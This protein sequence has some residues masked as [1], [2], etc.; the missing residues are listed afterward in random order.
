MFIYI[1]YYYCIIVLLYIIIVFIMILVLLFRL[2][3][4]GY[5]LLIEKLTSCL[6]ISLSISI[7][8][9]YLLLMICL[10]QFLGNWTTVVMEI[11]QTTTFNRQVTEYLLFGTWK[12]A[13]NNDNGIYKF[14]VIVIIW[15]LVQ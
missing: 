6:F 3:V 9:I 4:C 8:I 15:M 14:K 2:N 11:D 12:Y 7:T 13:T 10:K 1:V 5:L